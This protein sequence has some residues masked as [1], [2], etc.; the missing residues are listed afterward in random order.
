M[1]G[2]GTRYGISTVKVGEGLAGGSRVKEWWQMEDIW[3]LRVIM[4]KR[5]NIKT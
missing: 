2:N 5:N 4:T 1:G 3:S